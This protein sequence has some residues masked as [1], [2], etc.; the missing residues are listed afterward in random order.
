MTYSSP[1]NGTSGHLA[2]ELLKSVAWIDMRHVPYKSGPEAVTGVLS[3]DVL[4]F[5][6]GPRRIA[7]GGAYWSR[8]HGSHDRRSEEQSNQAE[9]LETAEDA[10]ENP[11]ERQTS[12]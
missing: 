4:H 6:Q 9:C 3:G 2:A 5:F 12:R 11:Q 7:A 8:Q 1:G 10:E